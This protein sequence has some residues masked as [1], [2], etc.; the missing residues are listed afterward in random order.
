MSIEIVVLALLAGFIALRLISVLGRHDE[1]SEPPQPAVMQ[2]RNDTGGTSNVVPLDA[3]TRPALALPDNLNDAARSG[4]E[5]IADADPFFDPVA[6]VDGARSAYRMVLEAFWRGDRNALKELVSDD[7]YDDFSA[8]IEAREKDGLSYENSLVGIENAEIM[9]ASRRGEMGEI[10][11]RF[12]A[13]LIAVTRDA[14]GKCR[15]R[16]PKAMRP[17]RMTSGPSAATCRPK[18]PAWVL[19]ETDGRRLKGP[20][21]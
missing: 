16:P 13:D 12:D 1:S 8:A 3:A 10:T 7:I 6:F 4:L 20:A 19:I 9:S 2:R 15:R 17:R 5:L 14:D 11:V 18:T 21:R